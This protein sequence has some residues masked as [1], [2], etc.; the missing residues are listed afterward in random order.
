MD[1]GV[2]LQMKRDVRDFFT[3]KRN[4][5]SKK[6]IRTK[7]NLIEKNLFNFPHFKKATNVMFFVSFK[8]EPFTH[9]MIDH[10]LKNKVVLAPK[11][12]GEALIPCKLTSSR[13][14]SNQQFNVPEPTEEDFFPVKKIDLVIVPGLA[15]TKEGDRIGYGKG[16]FDRFL[17]K[18][19]AYKIGLCFDEFITKELPIER[20]DIKMN[21]VI[22]DKRVIVI[23]NE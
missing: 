19:S 6:E 20:H 12:F 1:E 17:E 21:T 11:I 22:T 4:E 14:V 2:V 13:A 5:L 15:F 23:N 8:K 18:T 3:K 10:A 16:Y 9:D 7:S